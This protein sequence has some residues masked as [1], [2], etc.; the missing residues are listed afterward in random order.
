MDKG[1]LTTLKLDRRINTI[2]K[3]LK[4][5]NWKSSYLLQFLSKDVNSIADIL[6]D[7]LMIDKKTAIDAVEDAEGFA[8]LFDE[9]SWPKRN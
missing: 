8:T 3:S 1:L 6:V 5:H 7:T 4:E 2:F 9:I